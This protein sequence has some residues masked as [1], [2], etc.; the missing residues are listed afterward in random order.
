MTSTP[1]YSVDTLQDRL[2]FI[3]QCPGPDILALCASIPE[4]YDRLPQE[5]IAEL[6]EPERIICLRASLICWSVTAGTQVPRK[7]QL[8]AI[9]A[10]RLGRNSLVSAGTGSGKTL[11]IAMNILLDD[12]A[13]K[14]ITL[15]VSPLKR[16]Q[17]GQ[18]D[19]FST[20]YGIR[21]FAINDDTPRDD[22]WWTV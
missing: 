2:S 4:L 7:M 19:A 1:I 22:T 3:R 20:R 17:A 5:Y 11:P 16:L 15:T 10:D 9:L 18:Q 13:K 8:R 12:P 14:Y 6:Q 21:T